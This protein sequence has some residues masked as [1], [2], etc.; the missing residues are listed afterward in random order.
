[1]VYCAAVAVTAGVAEHVAEKGPLVVKAASMAV[2]LNYPDP[3]RFYLLSV[4]ID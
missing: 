3:Y 4:D 2:P 1:M